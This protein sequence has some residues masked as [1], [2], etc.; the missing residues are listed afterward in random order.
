MFRASHTVKTLAVPEELWDLVRDVTQWK[1]WLL[2][3]D[4][5]QL[6]GQIAVGARGLLC[7]Y[8]GAVHQMVICKYDL[9]R[10]E[11]IVSLRFGVKMHLLIDVSSLPTGSQVRV[12]GE[13]L[14]AMSI[15]HAF[16]WGRNLKM[17]IVPATRRLG[18]LSQRLASYR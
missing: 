18:F 13:L 7:L 3:I 14:G 16:G 9:G 6:N 1:R 17:G 15:L 5:V 2:G 10:L 4:Q 8:G 12:E 11:A